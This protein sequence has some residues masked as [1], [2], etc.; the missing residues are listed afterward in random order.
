M[1]PVERIVRRR[2]LLLQGLLHAGAGSRFTASTTA[3]DAHFAALCFYAPLPTGA[4]IAESARVPAPPWVWR[5]TGLARTRK[6]TARRL[7]ACERRSNEQERSR[8]GCCIDTALK[9][10]WARQLLSPESLKSP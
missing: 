3:A 1:Q 8:R 10:M 7:V 5:S 9:H 4:D 2:L 6:S